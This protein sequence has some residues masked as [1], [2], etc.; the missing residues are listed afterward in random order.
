MYTGHRR[1]FNKSV[2]WH[3]DRFDRLRKDFGNNIYYRL[4]VLLK[5]IVGGASLLT[6]C[7]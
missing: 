2:K 7:V 3:S 6:L 5:K 1:T 4:I